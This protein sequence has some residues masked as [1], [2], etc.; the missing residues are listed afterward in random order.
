LDSSNTDNSNGAT[1]DFLS[2]CRLMLRFA[3]RMGTD[4]STELE[5]EIARLDSV[6]KSQD[7][8][9]ISDVPPVL[10]ADA[11]IDPKVDTKPDAPAPV[12]ASELVLKVHKE[13]SAVVAPATALSLQTSEP[14]PGRRT[15]VGGMPWVVK[16]AAAL[17]L[18]SAVGFV[19]S[20]GMIAVA[21][22]KVD[23]V[24]KA[25]KSAPTA[26]VPPSTAASP[27]R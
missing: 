4:I 21:A 7:L 24:D 5:H 19:F 23:K 12:A 2:D 9:P 25:E 27:T 10:V 15:F 13:L 6:L 1:P 18:L 11:K 8:P 22:K 3:R 20:A 17:A 26:P 14:P 16:W